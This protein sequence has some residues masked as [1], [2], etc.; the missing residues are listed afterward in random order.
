MSSVRE[1]FEAL[2]DTKLDADPGLRIPNML[3]AA[4]T[5]EF[6][7]MFIQG[8]D[9]AQSDP[10]TQHVIAALQAMVMA[11]G[12]SMTASLK[13][14]WRR[15]MRSEARRATVV[16]AKAGNS[17]SR[18]FHQSEREPWGSMSISTTGPAP[19]RWAWTAR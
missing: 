15:I 17:A 1:Q 19:A 7:G 13:P 11:G 14:C 5:G 18:S 4:M 12:V 9:I 6:R 3:D 2:W 10:N 16:W 8:E